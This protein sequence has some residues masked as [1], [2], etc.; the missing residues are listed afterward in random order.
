[1]TAIPLLYLLA[2]MKLN[3]HGGDP[4][5]YYIMNV[6]DK[7]QPQIFTSLQ[8]CR[9]Y[10]RQYELFYLTNFDVTAGCDPQAY[11]LTAMNEIMEDVE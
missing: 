8:H 7:F 3:L 4:I 10:V 9:A 2:A 6:S 11:R 1:M 5:P